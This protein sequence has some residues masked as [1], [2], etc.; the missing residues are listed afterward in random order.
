MID[1]IHVPNSYR[2]LFQQQ[3]PKRFYSA[4]YLPKGKT[5][6]DLKPRYTVALKYGKRYEPWITDIKPLK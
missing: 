1:S 6:E 3:V 2:T 5:I 4:Y